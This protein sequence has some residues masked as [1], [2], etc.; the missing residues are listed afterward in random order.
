MRT[1]RTALTLVVALLITCPALAAGAKCDTKKAAPCPAAQRVDKMVQGLTLTDDQ[2]TSLAD[3]KKE[4]GPK[5]MAALKKMDVTTPEQKKACAE[6]TKEAKAAGKK[7]KE[8]AEA[9][10]A[11]VTLTDDQK[12][13]LADAKKE[14]K[15][16]EK[17][18]RAKVMDV[19][20]PEQKEQVKKA[21]HAKKKSAN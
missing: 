7:G 18:L 9:G 19:L 8:L 5:L 11:A 3:V 20:T 10:K 13:Q 2:K 17:E 12:T 6:A 15:A 14:M 1:A 21:H 4:Y 16:L